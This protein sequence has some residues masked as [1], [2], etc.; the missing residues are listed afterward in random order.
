MPRSWLLWLLVCA[1]GLL[2]GCALPGVFPEQRTLDLRPPGSLPK[3]RI[4]DMPPPITVSN[5]EPEARER[6]LSLDDAIRI[7]LE[8][9]QVVR[10]LAGVS[11]VASGKTI[12]DP[13]IS[14]TFID[15]EQARFDPALEV[16]NTFTRTEQPLGVLTPFD[17]V[18]SLIRGNRTDFY[19]LGTALT[20]TNAAGGTARLGFMDDLG[21]FQPGVVP[22]N[23]QNQHALTLSY[24]Q[25][26]LQG[27]GPRANLAPVVIAR[28]NTERSY[29]QLKDAVQDSVRGVIEA[30]W[31][32]V[33]ARTDVWARQQQVRQGEEAFKLADARKRAGFADEAE[34]A[35]ARS[36]LANFKAS[37][38]GAE[39]SVIQRE[40]ALRNIMGLSPSDRTRLVP[41][42]PPS[43][44]R[45]E[46]DWN[47]ILRLAEER[48]PDL[49]E[50]KLIV[51]ADEQFLIQARNQALPKVD[52]TMLYQWNGLEGTTP[53]GTRLATR[54][55]QFSDWTLGVNFAV[56]LGLRKERAALRQQEL[57]LARDW[58]NLDQGLQQASFGLADSVR[59]LA[60]YHDQYRSFKDAREDARVNLIAQAA[61]FKAGVRKD[62][63]F[64]NVLQA[65]TDWGNAVS[66]E[67]QS[68]AQ[69]NTELANLET[70]TGT[71]LETHD[72]YFFEE[73]FAAI[74]P[75]GRL[76]HPR[77]YPASVPPGPN[78]PRY[79]TQATPAEN[80]FELSPP[81]KLDEEKGVPNKNV[82]QVRLLTPLVIETK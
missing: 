33:F 47:G 70:Q 59:N 46:V 35:Q 55:S 17:P 44:S 11:A 76:G 77:L 68:L 19:N 20:R 61:K 52:T 6:L 24:T 27:A 38:I 3:A 18:G 34:V 79:P 82:P 67:A 2:A 45:L 39:A 32:L 48:R 25:P 43:T 8:N 81:F 56:P 15:Q 51:E 72:I 21:R 75:F 57:I 63:I 78:A 23:P 10:V 42:T 28:L 5:P 31:A 69:Y 64:L 22:L 60:L 62:V 41:I 50:L 13:A 58:A 4:P 1:G 9:S 73:R 14:N 7:T 80:F 65:I 53:G 26:L 29:F 37:L 12:Y 16:T 54:G 49:I 36:A 30:Y 74:G 71:I 40:S 66:A